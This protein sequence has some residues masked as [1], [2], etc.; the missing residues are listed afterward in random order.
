MIQLEMIKPFF[1]P[2][3]R[4]NPAFGKYMLKEYI[5]VL[6]LDYLSNTPAI[7]KLDFI[8]G[9]HLRLIKGIDR[10]SED[11]DFD[12]KAFSKTAFMEMTDGVV[13]FLRNY[14][15]PARVKD[16]ENKKLE[17]FRRNI[18]FPGLLY[19]MKLSAHRDERFLIKIE[20]QDQGVE[21][22]SEIAHIKACG[23]FFPV[24]VPPDSVICAMKLA[25][26]LDRQKGRD[27]YDAIF[28]L[29]QTIPDFTFLK[30]RCGISNMKELKNAARQTIQAV[31][32]NSKMKDFQHLVFNKSNSRKMLRIPEF[33]N[34]L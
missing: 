10:F 14:G 31:N 8:G 11:L 4:N 30:E 25:A 6:M 3:I 19:D 18:Y 23:M 26:M 24:P 34:A 1:S 29:S 16:R 17:A 7:R 5:Q 28:L 33:I 15:L 22:V 12:C 32:L 27:F 2:Q 13:R 9:T 20:C 21:Y